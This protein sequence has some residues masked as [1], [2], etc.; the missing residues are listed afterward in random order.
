MSTTTNKLKKNCKCFFV[1]ELYS[2]TWHGSMQ[3]LWCVQVKMCREIIKLYIE[4][5]VKPY[6]IIQLYYTQV[7]GMIHTKRKKSFPPTVQPYGTTPRCLIQ[8]SINK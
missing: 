5:L 4:Y 6:G 2:R 3:A 8:I 1:V 7:H